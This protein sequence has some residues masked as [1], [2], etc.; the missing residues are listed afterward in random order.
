MERQKQLETC[1]VISTGLI[2]FWF[3]NGAKIFLTIALFIGLIGIFV[4]ALAK[5]INWAWYKI[6]DIMGFVMSKVLLSIVFF[7]FLFPVSLL[8]KLFKKNPL[9]LKKQSDTYWTERKHK[10]SA[11]DLED[12]W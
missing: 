1:L 9:Q 5:W 2:V 4:P 11:K 10:Y 6:S 8:N 3:I 7:G 12:V